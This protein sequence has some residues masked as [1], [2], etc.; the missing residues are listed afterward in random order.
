[1]DRHLVSIK[2]GIVG[3]TYQW[4][5]LD[6][7]AFYQDRLKC[8]DSQPVERRGTVQHNRMLLD[9]VFQHIPYFR[10]ESLYHLLGILNIVG[11][12]ILNQ[13]FHNEW[14]KQLDRHLFWKAALVDLKFRPYDD[15][16]TSGI[17]D[18]LSKQV[19]TETSG[20]SFQH[21]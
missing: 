13:L 11:G 9:N 20:L 1:M 10:L 14:L 19:L 3:R 5:Q 12:S 16:R 15:N 8:L 7:L 21:I 6:R 17:V 4:M 18:T 2:V